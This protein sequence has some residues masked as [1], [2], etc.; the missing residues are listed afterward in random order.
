V[1]AHIFTL[2]HLTKVEVVKVEEEFEKI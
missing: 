1:K 2:S